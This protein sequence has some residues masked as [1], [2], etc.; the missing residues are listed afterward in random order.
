MTEFCKIIL[1][2][3]NSKSIE[4]MKIHNKIK[5][6]IF[7]PSNVN[8]YTINKEKML[9]STSKNGYLI[10]IKKKQI[11]ANISYL[12]NLNS[13][14]KVGNY[15]LGALDYSYICQI[16]T[17][18][19]EIL[20]YYYLNN[21]FIQIGVNYIIDVGNKFFLCNHSTLEVYLFKFK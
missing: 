12:K 11:E 21:T 10:N 7:D 5:K 19:W 2:D 20:N 17:K 3:I 9:L 14:E 16:N 4:K 15:T 18:T 6:F 13:L 8:C 1:Y